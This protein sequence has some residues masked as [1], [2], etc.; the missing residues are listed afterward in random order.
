MHSY[1][2]QSTFY[3]F[4]YTFHPTDKDFIDY[5][6]QTVMLNDLF[7]HILTLYLLFSLVHDLQPFG[8]TQVCFVW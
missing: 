4:H 8:S 7:L 1:V 6:A 3:V 2:Y 5:L